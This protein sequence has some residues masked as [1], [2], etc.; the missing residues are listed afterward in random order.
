MIKIDKTHVACAVLV[1]AAGM[2]SVATAQSNSPWLPI[3]G[4]AAVSLS[5]VAQSGDSAYVMGKME[6]P[7]KDITGGA[8]TKYRRE[9]TGL[10]LTYGVADMFSADLSLASGSAKVGGA[11]RSSG[12]TD[13]I[14]GL[15][16]RALDEY[17]IRAAPTV[18]LRFAGIIGGNY[19]GARLAALGKA[20]NGFQVGVTVGK[21]FSQQLRA[22]ASVGVEKLG[23]SI[24][25]AK[26]FDVNVGY[27]PLSALTLSLGYA[28]KHYGGSLDIA[29][30][31]FT[32]AA[33]QRVKEERDSV[34]LGA[35]YAIAANQSVAL[36]IGKTVRGRN[37]V[38]D[39]SIIGLGYTI[40][41]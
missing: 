2:S 4:D 25:T 20:E 11:D 28:A 27:S 3:P 30:P 37:T 40:G 38:K 1:A 31:G 14:L 15:N 36:S 41:F 13:A 22:W 17:E 12:L 23:G 39:D 18:T 33:F 24:P 8:A 21:E 16:Y 10:K 34:R 29:G 26:F 5:Y 9:S 19:D 7:I 35:S 32:P 6:V